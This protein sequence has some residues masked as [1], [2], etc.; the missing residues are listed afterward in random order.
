M[1]NTSHDAMTE[2]SE[3]IRKEALA[4]EAQH[5]GIRVALRDTE[6]SLRSDP[7][8][9]DLKTRLEDLRKRLEKLDKEAPWINSDM[10]PPYLRG[11]TSG[12]L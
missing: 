7:D 9:Q 3:K 4:L 1:D 12:P 5:L 11:T 2:A 8:N 10:T 6:A